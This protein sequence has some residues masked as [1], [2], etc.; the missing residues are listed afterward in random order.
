M[1]TLASSYG[2]VIQK[3]IKSS[4]NLEEIKEYFIELMH[5]NES[6]ENEIKYLFDDDSWEEIIKQCSIEDFNEILFDNYCITYKR[7]G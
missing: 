5:Q 4:T 2:N 7:T 1:Y 3:K 6:L